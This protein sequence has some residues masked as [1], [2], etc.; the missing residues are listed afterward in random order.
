MNKIFTILF[1][2]LFCKITYA[3]DCKCTVE[4]NVNSPDAVIIVDTLLAGKGKVSVEINRGIHVIRVKE[5]L[6]KWGAQ[7]ITDTVKTD[8][9]GKK[10]SFSYILKPAEINSVMPIHYEVVQTNTNGSFFKSTTFKILL[11]SAA[12][13]GGAAAYLKSHADKKYDDYK[14][15]SSQ[16]S[17]DESNR[18][19]LYSG[20]ALGLLQVNFGYLIYKFLTD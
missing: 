7:E 10:Y 8:I 11:G 19:D 3:Q 18:Y 5:S 15:S 14:R 17:L 4:V 13:L 20:I 2:L 9:C 6:L 16:T 12:V 1:C